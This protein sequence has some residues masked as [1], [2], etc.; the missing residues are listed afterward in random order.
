VPGGFEVCV[1]DDASPDE[2]PAVLARWADRLTLRS[3]H[4]EVNR[5]PATGRNRAWEMA[6]ADIV[7]FTDD[8]CVPTPGWLAAHAAAHAGED[9]TRTTVAVGRT[10][11]NP[12]QAHL[13]GTFSRTLRVDDA[14]YFQTC[15]LSMPRDLLVSL[16]GFDETFRRAAGEDTDL[17]L[18]AVESGAEAVFLPDAL[19]H[20][21]VRASSVRA[22]VRD[23]FRWS[24]ITLVVRKHPLVR[25]TLV[26]RT[27]FWKQS[28]PPAILAA[29]GLVA[30]LRR[31]WAVLLVL[32]WLRL[33]W[34]QHPPVAGKA[35]L[36]QVLPALLAVDLAEVASMARGSVRHRTLLL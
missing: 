5:G 8:D 18:R 21:D 28:H 14:R 23:A 2:T 16:G 11:P 34:H 6:R 31:P 25:T 13:E 27:W 20:H 26:H 36:L 35:E 9:R 4:G 17:G 15:N 12:D 7:V 1:Y 30:A 3:R 22:T 33:R 19:V 24:D 10:A 32:P 29:I